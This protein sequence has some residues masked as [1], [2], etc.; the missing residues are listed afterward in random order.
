V[1]GSGTGSGIGSGSSAWPESVFHAPILRG[2]DPA[3]RQAIVAAGR[4][5]ELEAGAQ[6]FA[7]DELGDSFYVLARG[8]VELTRPARGSLD[9]GFEPPADPHTRIVFAGDT[10]GEEAALPGARRRSEARAKTAI[11]VAEIPAPLFARALGRSGAAL[12]DAP[13]QRLLRRRATAELL[14]AIELTR[15]LPEADLDALL[16]AAEHQVVR[17]GEPVYAAG[18]RPDGLWLIVHGLVQ[19]QRE[20]PREIPGGGVVIQAY[21]GDGDL[22]GDAE[23]LADQPRALTAVAAGETQLLRLPPASF[24]ALIDRHPGL[25][26]RLRRITQARAHRQAAVVDGAAH[27]TRHVFADLYRMQMARSLLTIDQDACVRCGHCAWSC[28]QVHG[29]ARL[30]RRG[31]K[32]V[33]ALRVVDGPAAPRELLLPNSCQHCKDPVCMLDCPTGAIGRE[34]E[35]EVFIRESLCTGCGNCAKACPWENIRMAPRP[36]ASTAKAGFDEVLVAAAER[37]GLSLAAMFPEV[38]TKCDLCRAYEAPA[39]VQACPTEAI[40]RL[41]PERDF[42]EVAD[43][44]GLGSGVG[45]GGARRLGTLRAGPILV[46]TAGVVGVAGVIVGAGLHGQRTGQGSG[47]GAQQS[48]GHSTNLNTLRPSAG[49]GLLAGVLAAGILLGL[50]AHAR[51]KRRVRAWMRPRVRASRSALAGDPS[52]PPLPRS[53]LRPY[54]LAHLSLGLILPGLVLAHAGFAAP[55]NLAGVLALLTWLTLGLG[56]FGAA[57][58]AIV[59]R[60]LTRIEHGGALPEDLARER[61]RL[62]DRLQRELSGKPAPVKRLT[63]ERLLPW[64]RTLLGRL[65]LLGSGRDLGQERARL[66]GQIDGWIEPSLR[67][68]AGHPRARAELFADLEPILR[69]CV[70]LRALP[71][72]RLLHAALRAWMPAHVLLTGALLV[73]LVAHI[74][75]VML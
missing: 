63:G 26:E 12:R 35:G 70:E 23:L 44:L 21:L 28:E 13:E 27:A 56:L 54:Y 17:R 61:E 55:T 32:V 67:E 45:G 36:S 73:A 39:C 64:T 74:V 20:V 71:L 18:D 1:I 3:G 60:R 47:Q 5:R 2:L 65:A 37:R 14:A 10:F 50:V 48:T 8:E 6:V 29:V 19:L 62:L 46:A 40:I 66:R 31:D 42:A 33:T 57:A 69:T 75:A 22:F 43:I 16:D 68:G 15:T 9:P 38:A 51:P 49:P 34:A 7:R 24:R 11:L 58:Y 25:V 53:K 59:P 4:L 41:E 30:V 52:S 72:R